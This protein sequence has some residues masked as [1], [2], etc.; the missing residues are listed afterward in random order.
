MRFSNRFASKIL[1]MA[2]VGLAT[3]SSHAAEVITV[4]TAAPQK[5]VDA[6]VPKFEK[7]TG[8]EV[9]VIKAGSGEL[10]N[11][12]T[13]E[14]DKPVADVLWSV[15]GTVIDFNPTLFS[16]YKSV[17]AESLIP[18]LVK[19]DAWSPFTAV[20]MVFIVNK[21][22][23]KGLKAPTSWLD[24]SKPDYKNLISSARADRSG[25]AFIQYATVMQIFS[26]EEEAARVYK[27]ALKNFVLSNSSG[28]VP[29]FVNDGES[30]IGITLEDAALQY[31]E[32]GGPVDIVY[33]SEGTALAPDAIA[34]VAGS[35]NGK[36]A[37]R[38]IDFI[39]SK[40]GQ[41]IVASLGRRPVR[42]DVAS[43]P[44]LMPLSSVPVMDYDFKWAAENR[45]RLI[46]NWADW[47]LDVQ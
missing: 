20:V 45:A 18:G 22:K 15:D 13:A 16:P 36:G 12:L 29:R 31:K 47:V 35:P 4:Y 9:Q 8:M 10:L 30:P 23:L 2:V 46:E 27:G 40:E 5:F 41:E 11:R 34:K 38:F 21:A 25:S 3:F 26:T 14:S 37:E 6:L 42:S 7:Q 43:N 17:H 33:P 32:G 44:L 28:A 19:S 39:L 1:S 24:L